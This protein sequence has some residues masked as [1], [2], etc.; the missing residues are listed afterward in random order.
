M[1]NIIYVILSILVLTQCSISY[2]F[3]GASIDYSKVKTLSVAF[4]P[5][6]ARLV[7]DPSLSQEFTEG[8]KDFFMRQTKLD[9]VENN[10]DLQYEGEITDY[11]IKPQSIQADMTAAQTRVT[12][13]VNV[14]FMNASDSEQDFEK[15][16]SAYVDFDSSENF[17]N[18]KET[19]RVE[20]LDQ[21][22]ENIFNES[23]ANW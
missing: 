18:V 7:A 12:M 21:I 22:F 1:K 14:R 20:L 19:I 17:E 2:K 11:E 15:S 13:R 5:N 10:G 6:E 8:L 9:L 3:T 4:F 16:F 23:V